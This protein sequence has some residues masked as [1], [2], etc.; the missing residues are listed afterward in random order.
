MASDNE[1]TAVTNAIKNEFFIADVKTGLDITLKKSDLFMHI[2]ILV[3]GKIT[4]KV[5][6]TIKII[7]EDSGITL[8]L[9]IILIYSVFLTKRFNEFILICRFDITKDSTYSFAG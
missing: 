9:L 8:L 6:A 7:F 1:R 5:R 3:K 4:N 2:I